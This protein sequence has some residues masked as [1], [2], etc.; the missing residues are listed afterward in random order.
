MEED[1]ALLIT[2]IRLFVDPFISP[3]F[4]IVFIGSF[5]TLLSTVALINTQFLEKLITLQYGDR[6]YEIEI[7]T[8]QLILGKLGAL[9]GIIGG[10][11]SLILSFVAP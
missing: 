3:H 9:I 8:F 6:G 2:N 11:I 5:V 10:I 4:F 7:T 1:I